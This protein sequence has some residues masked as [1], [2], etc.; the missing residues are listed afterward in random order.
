MR[1]IRKII[2]LL[3]VVLIIM[4]FFP[5]AENKSDTT[6]PTDLILATSPPKEVEAII[7]NACYDCHSNN[8]R[9]PWYANIEPVSYWMAAHIEE[10]REHLDFS[11]W[12]LYANKKKAHKLDEMIEAVT[13]GWM[14]LKSYTWIHNDAKLTDEQAK[15]IA[16]WAKMLKLTYETTDQ[17][18]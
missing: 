10:G 7:T 17:P 5:P 2:F 1:I 16:E 11:Q 14:P 13:E 4:Q 9:Y 8:T 12:E 15:T 18:Q 6:P 3:F